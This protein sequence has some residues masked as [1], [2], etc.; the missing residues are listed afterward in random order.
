MARDED[1]RFKAVKTCIWAVCGTCASVYLYGFIKL[2][3]EEPDC[4]YAVAGTD[5]HIPLFAIFEGT[6]YFIPTHT[7]SI[8]LLILSP[9]WAVLVLSNLSKW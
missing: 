8:I 2:I 4:C 5:N 7:L 9:Y 6:L 1:L 3:K